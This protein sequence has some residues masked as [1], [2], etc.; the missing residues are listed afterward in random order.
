MIKLVTGQKLKLNSIASENFEIKFKY[1][2]ETTISCFGL[3]LNRKLSDD[4]Y[5][6]FYN[7][8]K[9]PDNAIIMVASNTETVFKIDLK[10]LDK[11]ILNM[12]FTLTDLLEDITITIGSE[13]YIIKSSDYI[14]EKAITLIEIYFKDEWRVGAVGK[15]FNGG[16]DSLLIDFGGELAEEKEPTQS[17]KISL[18]KKIEKEAPQLISLVKSAKVSLAKVGLS[19]HKAKVA[20]CLDISASMHRSYLSEKVQAFVE[21][22]LALATRFDDDGEID[23]FVFGSSAYNY[24]TCNISNISG[25]VDNLIRNTPLQGGTYYHLAVDL[26]R[27]HYLPILN[28]KKECVHLD[29]PVYVMFLTDGDTANRGKCEVSIKESSYEPIFWSFMGIGSER[30]AFLSKLDELKGRLIDNA[31]LLVVKDP[32]ALPDEKLYD[33]LV[34]EYKNWIPQAKSKG[35]IS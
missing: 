5:M 6:I 32:V 8:E 11:K 15:G 31:S 20:L 7:Q 35:L 26:I 1:A 29:L 4:R 27:N 22:V 10:L 3:D 30:F 12:V 14:K 17:K 24:G 9:S 25:Y 13:N 23:V 19:D 18:D 34:K 33:E 16:L 28:T 2:K 21:R